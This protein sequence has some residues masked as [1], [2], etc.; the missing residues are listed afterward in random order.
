VTTAQ[1]ARA[2]PGGMESNISPEAQKII[3]QAS[4]GKSWKDFQKVLSNQN[5]PTQFALLPEDNFQGKPRYRVPVTGSDGRTYQMNADLDKAGVRVTGVDAKGN[6]T[7]DGPVGWDSIYFA[8]PYKG[9]NGITFGE[10]RI[11]MNGVEG[12]YEDPVS[13]QR[14]G[15]MVGFLQGHGVDTS[16]FTAKQVQETY[17]QYSQLYG[18]DKMDGPEEN[19]RDNFWKLGLAIDLAKRQ[20][21]DLNPGLRGYLATLSNGIYR[22]HGADMPGWVKDTLNTTGGFLTGGKFKIQPNEKLTELHNTEQQIRNYAKALGI[23]PPGSGD[24]KNTYPSEDPDYPRVL[25]NWS[26][27]TVTQALATYLNTMGTLNKQIPSGLVNMLSQ[28][29]NAGMPSIGSHE[30]PITL[31]SDQQRQALKKENPNGIWARDRNGTFWLGPEANMP[32]IEN[33]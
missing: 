15:Q 3:L 28:M 12:N 25:Q 22:E 8:S 16:N 10:H 29:K 18:K 31:F 14:V 2:Q 11:Y 6:V 27:N 33:P 13:E 1:A 7:L 20:A 21:I 23:D 19:Q 30:N 24:Y 17:A 9:S 5:L 26:D 32:R 4:G